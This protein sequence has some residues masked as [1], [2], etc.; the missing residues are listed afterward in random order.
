MAGKISSARI[1]NTAAVPNNLLESYMEECLGSWFKRHKSSAAMQIGSANELP[2]VERFSTFSWVQDFWE[3]GLVQWKKAPFVGVS[4]DGIATITVNDDDAPQIACVEIKTRTA[5]S[6]IERAEKAA[7][8]HGTKVICEFN[9]EVFDN[10]VPQSNRIQVLHQAL[11]TGLNYGVFV[12]SKVENKKGVV[13]QSVVVKITEEHKQ[14]HSQRLL[15]VGRSLLGWIITSPTLDRGYL[16]N[17]DFPD[18]VTEPQKKAI[19]SNFKLWCA[20]YIRIKGRG[21]ENAPFKPSQPLSTY[22]HVKQLDY[23]KGKWGLDKNTETC[24]GMTV[25]AVS[26][27][28]KYVHRMIAALVYN[29]WRCTQ[30]Q[31]MSAWI[32]DT[33]RQNRTVTFKGIRR[34][35]WDTPFDVHVFH[36]SIAALKDL[37]VQRVV[38]RMGLANLPQASPRPRSPVP[39]ATQGD[40]PQEVV[41]EINDYIANR[42][43]VS[44]RRKSELMH[45]T[46]S[47]I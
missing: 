46:Q 33:Q 34:K 10:C 20:Q 22:K 19:G 32:Q 44:L 3:I 21:N 27:E 45:M 36:L 43:K 14:E 37:E 5:P 9:D 7:E 42:K 28:Q 29:H 38:M 18:W 1:E 40:L 26:F 23:N 6:T 11:V 13:L 2:T 8:K 35:A 16:V 41:R 47:H 17:E 15:S 31:Q 30:A 39:V 12:T 24:K 25:G 4:P